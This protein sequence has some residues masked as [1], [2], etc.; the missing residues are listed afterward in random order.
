MRESSEYFTQMQ[1]YLNV[2]LI[3]SGLLIVKNNSKVHIFRLKIQ[4]FKAHEIKKIFD[5]YYTYFLPYTILG[6]LPTSKKNGND[7]F[8]SNERKF[9]NLRISSQNWFLNESDCGKLEN[10]EFIQIEADTFSK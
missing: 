4:R 5:F 1:V 7:F 6:K 9:L 8:G 10:Y 2:F 3:P